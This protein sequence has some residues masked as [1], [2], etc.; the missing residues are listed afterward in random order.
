MCHTGIEDYV[1]MYE[2]A[3]INIH[4]LQQYDI[5]RDVVHENHVV[6]KHHG[7]FSR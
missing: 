4:Y 6:S 1:C 3:V 7:E 2:Y 5:Y